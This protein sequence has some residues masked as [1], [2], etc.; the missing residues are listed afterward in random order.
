MKTTLMLLAATGISRE[1]TGQVTLMTA[2]PVPFVNCTEP[3]PPQPHTAKVDNTA[4][5]KLRYR[6]LIRGCAV[7]VAAIC[8]VLPLWPR[9][10]LRYGNGVSAGVIAVSSVAYAEMEPAR[11]R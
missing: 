2:L 8:E 1:R 4:M 7:G 11:R 9:D 10:E 5:A 6:S 3:P